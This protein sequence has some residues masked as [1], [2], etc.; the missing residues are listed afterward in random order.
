MKATVPNSRYYL[1][2]RR[3]TGDGRVLWLRKPEANK[4]QEENTS[5]TTWRKIQAGQLR[6]A[7]NVL[8]QLRQVATD[9]FNHDFQ[10]F[11]DITRLLQLWQNRLYGHGGSRGKE[12]QVRA[13]VGENEKRLEIK[14]RV[15]CAVELQNSE[16]SSSSSR[17]SRIARPTR[18]G[19]PLGCGALPMQCRQRLPLQYVGREKQQSPTKWGQ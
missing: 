7:S 19:Y 15:L 3:Y 4:R 2:K 17:S 6:K 18:A 9:A 8:A 11:G 10:C 12:G 14:T 13:V 5:I 16:N 1:S